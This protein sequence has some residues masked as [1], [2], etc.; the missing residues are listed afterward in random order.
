[1]KLLVPLALAAC[2]GNEPAL[3]P[4][5]AGSMMMGCNQADD[6]L[7]VNDELPYHAVSISRFEIDETEVTQRAYAAC[8]DDGACTPPSDAYDPNVELPVVYVDWDQANAFCHFVN[9]RLP[10]EAEWEMAARGPDGRIY[11]WGDAPPDCELAN[12]AGCGDAL[13][14]VGTHLA[15]ASYYGALDM[16]GNAMEWVADYYDASYY[17]ASPPSDPQGPASGTYRSKRGG[18]FLGD[19]QTVRVSYRVEGFPV[20]LANLGFRCAR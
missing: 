15:G 6:A 8:V 10:T 14:P 11:P 13:E 18:S 7:C 20:G 4:V 2:A 17:A 16:A 1:M 12:V 9:E 3:V 5:E 19:P